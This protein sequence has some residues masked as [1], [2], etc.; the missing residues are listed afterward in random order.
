MKE[1]EECSLGWNAL[2]GR[3]LFLGHEEALNIYEWEYDSHS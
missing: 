2:F 3:L 1:E